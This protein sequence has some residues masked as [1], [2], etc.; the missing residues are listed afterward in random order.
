MNT[1]SKK[2]YDY[3]AAFMFVILMIGMF[4]YQLV[5]AWFIA[6]IVLVLLF[7]NYKRIQ[8]LGK[9]Q[10]RPALTRLAV[11]LLAILGLFVFY[12]FWPA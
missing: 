9:D 3:L 12:N 5:T 4:G 6:P 11:G 10:T 1:E 7:I 8:L 2:F